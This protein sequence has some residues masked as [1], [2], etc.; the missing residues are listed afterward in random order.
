MSAPPTRDWTTATSLPQL[1]PQCQQTAGRVSPRYE[2]DDR[3]HINCACQRLAPTPE[4][5][6]DCPMH[7]TTAQHGELRHGDPTAHARRA[8]QPCDII[9]QQQLRIGVQCPCQANALPLSA[10]KVDTTLANLGAI[11]CRAS[12]TVSEWG[13]ACVHASH[14]SPTCRHA[15]QVFIQTACIDHIKVRPDAVKHVVHANVG[16]HICVADP[17]SLREQANNMTL[18]P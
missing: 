1:Y 13:N 9:Q 15:L 6:L 12:H 10:A 11:A 5:Q 4:R 2:F 14:D 17:W 7:W 8:T 3:A 16:A 18:V